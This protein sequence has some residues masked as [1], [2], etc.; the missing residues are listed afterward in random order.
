MPA[1]LDGHLG[2]DRTISAKYHARIPYDPAFFVDVI[3]RSGLTKFDRLLDLC[4]GQGEIA[5]QLTDHFSQIHAVD[6]SAEMLKYAPDLP[7]VT[8]EVADVNSPDWLQTTADTQ[9]D[10]ICVGRGVHWL[11]DRSLAHLFTNSLAPGGAFFAFQCDPDFSN[12]WMKPLMRLMN[13]FSGKSLD[14]K[15]YSFAGRAPSAV[16]ETTQVHYAIAERH[17]PWERLANIP[18]SFSKTGHEVAAR[19]EDYMKM[20]ERLFKPLIVDGVV[21]TKVLFQCQFARKKAGV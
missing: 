12:P 15:D 11:S 5:A 16:M 8:Y 1:T 19:S 13:A 2:F 3:D 7:N 18:L 6:G 10:A 14:L 21:P 9:Y 17:Y 4:T 20:C